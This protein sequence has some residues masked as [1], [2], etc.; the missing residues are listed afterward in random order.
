M[1]SVP[2]QELSS[3]SGTYSTAL[4]ENIP[5]GQHPARHYMDAAGLW[6]QPLGEQGAPAL[7]ATTGFEVEGAAPH[8]GW[9]WLSTQSKIYQGLLCNNSLEKTAMSA[10]SLATAAFAVEL[11]LSGVEITVVLGLQNH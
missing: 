7:E 1:Q 11:L 3:V 9:P 4:L 2:S 10:K 6:Q 8:F 5:P